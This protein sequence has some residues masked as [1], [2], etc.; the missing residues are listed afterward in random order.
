MKRLFQL[1]VTVLLLLTSGLLLSCGSDPKQQEQGDSGY[2]GNFL[3]W[4]GSG[5]TDHYFT[6]VL[7]NG[8]TGSVTNIGGTNFFPE[9]AYAPDGTLYGISDEL[10]VIDPATGNTVKIGTF[11]YE[12]S[13]I[14]MHGS[15]FSPD[16]TLYVVENNLSSDRVFSVNLTNAALTYIGEP[17]ALIWD[18][19]FASNGTLYGA[20]GDLFTLNA[21]NLSTLTTVGHIGSV[22]SPMAHDSGGKLFGMDIYPSTTIYSLN[23]NTGAASPVAP[24]GS[25]GLRSLVVERSSA[26]TSVSVF[27]KA[28]AVHGLSFPRAL[29]DLLKNEEAIKAM[30]SK[31]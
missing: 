3:S 28:A 17:T 22:V 14:L 23:R 25:F 15:A 21:A 24:T 5:D 29:E 12:A 26:V 30:R 27:H 1:T 11:Q 8:M 19:E 13:T 16:G 20:Y 10:H 2:A 6:L 18:L 9:I 31:N 4:T 7:V